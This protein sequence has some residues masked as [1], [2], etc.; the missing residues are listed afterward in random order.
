MHVVFCVGRL[1][2]VLLVGGCAS[3]TGLARQE[4]GCTVRRDAELPMRRER[5]FILLPARLNGHAV[6]TVLDTGAEISTISPSVAAQFDLPEDADSGRILRGVGGDVRTGSVLADRFGLDNLP[7]VPTRFSLS[8]ADVLPGLTPPVVGL[9]GIDLLAD[10]DLDLDTP[11]L[12]AALYSVRACPTF[13]P[14]RDGQ[15]VAITRLASGLS[16]VVAE[17]DGSAVRALLDTGAR[18]SFMTKR[19]AAALGV[20][21]SMLAADPVSIK[22]G[23]SQSEIDVRQHRFDQIALG[24]IRWHGPLVGIADVELPGVD[25][26][27]GIDLLG[28]QPIWISPSRGM[29]WLR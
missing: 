5:D 8:T 15:G 28:R 2:I 24:P 14:W 19:L 27:L 3:S 6:Q 17:V 12:R 4:S 26:L 29:L 21:D 7:G 1:L 13:R 25:M 22:I 23:I 16:L 10:R 20:T 18:T 11:N 9:L